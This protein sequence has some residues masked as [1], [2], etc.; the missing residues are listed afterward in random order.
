[1][2]Q[3]KKIVGINLVIL[4]V[5]TI[6]IQVWEISGEGI[7]HAG[8]ATLIFMMIAIGAQV[9]I[10]LI[11]SVIYFLK[12]NSDLGKAFLLSTIVVLLVGFSSCWGSAM[13]LGQA[14]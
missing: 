8:L 1:V 14:L 13:L 6:L 12:N 4:L 10:N 2:K 11:I 5:Y 3:L 9:A 7:D